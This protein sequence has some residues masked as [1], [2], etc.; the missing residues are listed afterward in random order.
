MVRIPCNVRISVVL[1]IDVIEVVLPV[2]SLMMRFETWQ[3]SLEVQ[4]TIETLSRE[5]DFYGSRKLQQQ[6]GDPDPTAT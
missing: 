6:D 1:L 2:C 5:D 3:R 4:N